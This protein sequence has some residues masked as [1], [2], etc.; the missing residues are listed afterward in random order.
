[1]PTA[2]RNWSKLINPSNPKK[3]G[4]SDMAKYLKKSLPAGWAAEPTIDP[5]KFAVDCANEILPIAQ[6]AHNRLSF[7]G[8]KDNA[9]ASCLVV[10]AGTA[11]ALASADYPTYARDVVADEIQ[12]AGHRL[13]DLLLVILQ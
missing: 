11:T 3:V 5:A 9:H 2:A 4:L 13:A 7:G 8:I 10:T 6:E 1:M 12:K